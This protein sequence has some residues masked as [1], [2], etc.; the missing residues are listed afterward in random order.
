MIEREPPA[1][2]RPITV[3][4]TDIV[5]STDLAVTLGDRRWRELR[6][7]HN[8][9]IRREL[10]KF[11][12]TELDTSGDGFFA[13]FERPIDGVSCAFAISEEVRTIGIDVRIGMHADKDAPRSGE[14]D[15]IFVA[16]AN[17]VSSL[18][19]AGEVL[20]TSPMK[21]MLSDPS[22][23]LE[24]RGMHTLKGVSGELGIFAVRRHEPQR[25]AKAPLTQ[26]TTI[27]SH[28]R[29]RA[30]R[31]V[32]TLMFTDI[33]GATACATKLGPNAW[34][35]VREAHDALIDRAV[36]R[37]GGHIVDRAGDRFFATFER[38]AEALSCACA[39][40]DGV[41]PLG[42]DLRIALH[43][44]EVEDMGDKVGGIA[45]H[46][47]ARILALAGPGEILVS[48]TLKGLV[49][50]AGLTF[51]EKGQHELKG[52]PGVRSVFAMMIR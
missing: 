10:A 30:G 19:A 34:R 12:G 11:S 6:N 4:F 39:I 37:Y 15:W 25:R 3:M 29:D 18:A 16:I 27:D 33:V 42:V 40:Q 14:F 49:E 51:E 48:S 45:I 35:Q 8:E 5:G 7:S 32:L 23:R 1:F 50:G 26:G 22:I 21:A 24:S 46:V 2:Q 43:T 52:V 17:R 36:E 38:P 9:L 44:G 41:G 20:I 13:R 47:G 28:A 31:S